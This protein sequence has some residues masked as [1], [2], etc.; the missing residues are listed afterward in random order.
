MTDKTQRKEEMR[1][2]QTFARAGLNQ[3]TEF[4]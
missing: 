1:K 3:M 4:C 2:D